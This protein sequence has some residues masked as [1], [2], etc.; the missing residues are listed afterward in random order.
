MSMGGFSPPSFPYRT[1]SIPIMLLQSSWAVLL[2][3][4]TA[5]FLRWLGLAAPPEKVGTPTQS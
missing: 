3:C 5:G 4:A 2:L 1:A